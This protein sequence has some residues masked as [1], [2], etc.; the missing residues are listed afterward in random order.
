MRYEPGSS[1]PLRGQDTFKRRRLRFEHM[2]QQYYGM[3]FMAYTLINLR[4]FCGTCNSQPV[5]PN[6]TIPR[7]GLSHP[8]TGAA[9]DW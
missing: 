6:T 8:R 3:K 4:A 5:M 9:I 7:D 1:G 2:Q